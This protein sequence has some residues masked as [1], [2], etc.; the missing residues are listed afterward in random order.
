MYKRLEYEVFVAYE[1]DCVQE[2]ATTELIE[3]HK[4][5][6]RDFGVSRAL[7]T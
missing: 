1:E 4:V 5:L 6:V 7:K 2:A 3:F